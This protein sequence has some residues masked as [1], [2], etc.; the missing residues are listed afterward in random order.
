MLGKLVSHFMGS[1]LAS[2]KRDADQAMHVD[3]EMPTQPAPTPE[4]MAAAQAA[5][6]PQTMPEP[7]MA[8]KQ[9]EA[10]GMKDGGVVF[11]E[12][13]S[14]EATKKTVH[15]AVSPKKD[16]P[17]EV[18]HEDKL[19]AVYKAMGIKGYADGGMVGDVDPSQLPSGAPDPKDPDFWDKIKNTL[20]TLSDSPAGKVAGFAFNP[21]GASMDA[22]K[23][24][25]PK[26]LDAELPVVAPV[27][28]K[29][30]S[31]AS[32]LNIPSPVAPSAPV[33]PAA[34][35]PAPVNAPVAP[36]PTPAAPPT[37]VS[38]TPAAKG[39]DLG[40]LFHQDTSKLTEG[41]NPED[42]QNLANALHS[43]QT[44]VGSIIAQAVA[45][46]GD[47]FAAKG[48]RDQHALGTV[49][50]LQ[51]DQRQEALANFD[52]ARQ[53]RLEKIDVQTKMGNNALQELAAKD[54]YGVDEHLNKMLGAPTGTAHK[55]LPLYFQ[56]RAAEVAAGEKD[57][58]LYMKA[59]EQ[60]AKE[61]DDALKNSSV[62]SI[63]PSPAQIEASGKKLAD[64]YY[65]RAKGN[66][67]FQ[68][69]DGQKAVWIPAKNVGKARQMDPH[70]QIVQ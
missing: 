1:P 13:Q 37:P 61:I 6:L 9:G 48:G 52:K 57:S 35:A 45:G 4:E 15:L 8:K 33:A 62:L 24:V 3:D 2:D 63:K 16:E 58:E 65:N 68:P 66:I 36:M 46:L 12:N 23:T 42:R 50:N 30:A 17:K 51:K 56:M 40:N 20:S 49:F 43:G 60:A 25:V 64:Q 47:A 11:M 69:S 38:A 10:L 22:A 5:A 59:H 41:V 29:L 18:T 19:K 67:L 31:A 53:Q 70:G 26:V 27:A 14:P 28:A 32:G 7:E 34:A 21:I 55:D 44:G 54:S 39:P